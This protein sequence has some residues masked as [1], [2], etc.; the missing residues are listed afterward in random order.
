L[1]ASPPVPPAFPRSRLFESLGGDALKLYLWLRERARV[2]APDPSTPA[3]LEAA[4]TS[5]EVERAVGVSKNTVTKLARE[6]QA[7]GVASFESGR[8]GYLF[9]LGEVISSRTRASDLPLTATVFYLDARLAADLPGEAAR[10][11]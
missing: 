8:A 7:L 9:R 4:V 10:G 2:V 5:Q 6:L 1:L 3:Y 11:G